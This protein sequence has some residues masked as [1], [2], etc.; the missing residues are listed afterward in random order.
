MLIKKKPLEFVRTF[1][2]KND[3]RLVLNGVFIENDKMTATDEHILG[4]I[5]HDKNLSVKDYP[6]VPGLHESDLEQPLKPVIVPNDGVDALIRAIVNT[7]QTNKG[8]LFIAGTTDLETTTP[9]N[10][11]KIKGEYPNT[12]G[13]IPWNEVTTLFVVDPA[14][15]ARAM[16]AAAKLGLTSVTFSQKTEE[17]SYPIKITGKTIDGEDVTIAVM[18]LREKQ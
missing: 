5:S 3:T 14:L 6:K 12:E 1:A 16:T 8:P 11:K 13:A 15:L 18:A 2:G 4:Q 7:T 10:V 17:N 9:I